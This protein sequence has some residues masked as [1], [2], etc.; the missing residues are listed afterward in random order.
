MSTSP[1]QRASGREPVALGVSVMAADA[2]PEQTCSVAARDE[3]HGPAG[4]DD[5]PTVPIAVHVLDGETSVG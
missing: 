2:P 4:A 3:H 1:R 5:R